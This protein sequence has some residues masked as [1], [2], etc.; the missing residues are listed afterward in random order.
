MNIR[1]GALILAGGHSKRMNQ[2]KPFLNYRGKSFLHAISEIYFKSGIT[3]IYT[4]INHSLVTGS[5]QP[6]PEPLYS[7]LI[8]NN[9]PEHGRFYSL[10]L[11]TERVKD[12]DFCFIHNIDNPFLSKEM[13]SGL[14]RN[15]IKNGFVVPTYC[16]KG[17]HPIL[18]SNK[19]IRHIT[20]IPFSDIDFRTI[21]SEFERKDMPVNDKNILWNINTPGDYEKYIIKSN[22]QVA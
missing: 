6:H 13:I 20:S 19:I 10:K 22:L 16:G 3:E 12:L 5:W 15:K 1:C 2:P 9:H 8:L 7:S 14:L 11:G 4:V 17:G 21:L 18:I